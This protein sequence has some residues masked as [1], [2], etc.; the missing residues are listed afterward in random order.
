[1]K[2]HSEILFRDIVRLGLWLS[3]I[4]FGSCLMNAC[5][6]KEA[7]SI[8][9]EEDRARALVLPKTILN[10]DSVN[11]LQV[12]LQDQVQPVLGVVEEK[13]NS[14]LFR[15]VVAFTPGSVYEVYV[16][17]KLIGSVQIPSP[18]HLKRSELSSLYPAVDT[19][20][21]NLLKIYLRFSSPMREGEALQYVHLLN[22]DR[23]TLPG[24]FL[25]L[26]PELWN[27]E[28]TAL[29]LWLDPG[30]IKR[31][32][33]PNRNLGNPLQQSH[34]YIL[35]VSQEWKNVQGAPLQQSFEKRFFVEGRDSIS[36]NPQSWAVKAPGANSRELLEINF[37]EP[38]DHFLLGETIRVVDEKNQQVRGEMNVIDKG[39]AISFVPG[40]PW[41]SG[42]YRIQVASYLEDL[43]GNNLVRP[44]DRD[45]KTQ[46][47]LSDTNLFE[48]VFTIETN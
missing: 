38:L 44:F 21:E 46:K 27:K 28:R 13:T 30:R 35:R 34:W 42:R 9:W 10:S 5:K 26:Q 39:R 40:Q 45:I 3:L 43:A 2:N 11:G 14:I 22:E 24:V 18:V 6:Q 41:Q 17:N 23:D 7:I 36:P 4:F 37:G 20:P 8:V 29:T 1:M 15:P 31:D 19:V 16:G 48:R 32:L 47:T 12:R 33:I 25:D